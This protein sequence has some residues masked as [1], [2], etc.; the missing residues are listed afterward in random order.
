[1]D[2]DAQSLRLHDYTVLAT[3]GLSTLYGC[4]TARHEDAQSRSLENYD[5]QLAADSAYTSPL[6]QRSQ[7]NGHLDLRNAQVGQSSAR[8]RKAALE[9]GLGSDNMSTTSPSSR[10]QSPVSSARQIRVAT[11]R[12]R[13]GQKRT[14]NGSQDQGTAVG[15]GSRLKSAFARVKTDNTTRTDTSRDVE[16]GGTEGRARKGKAHVATADAAIANT[17]SVADTR[18]KEY[19]EVWFDRYLIMAKLG[20]G[21]FSQ[22]FLA[23]DLFCDRMG[24]KHDG[25][26]LVTIKRMGAREGIIGISDYQTISMLNR[27]DPKERVPIV[28]VYDIFMHRPKTWRTVEYDTALRQLVPT[29]RPPHGLAR[30]QYGRSTSRSLA[31]SERQRAAKAQLR[32]FGGDNS[33]GL[34]IMQSETDVLASSTTGVSG[35]DD[36][37][38][39]LVMEP[40]LGKTLHDAFPQRTSAVYAAHDE[41]IAKQIHMDMIRTVIRQL[42]VALA[43]MHKN[44]LLHADVKT[45]NIICVDD[46]SLRV[47]LIDFGNAVS[48]SDVPEYYTTFE[49][50]TVWFRAPEVAYQRPFG[51][52]IDIWSIGCIMCELWLSRP[53][54]TDMDNHNLISSIFKLRGPPPAHLYSAS[55]VYAEVAKLWSGRPTPGFAPAVVGGRQKGGMHSEPSL[56]WDPQLRRH[57]LKHSL[58]VEDDDFVSLADSLLEY[59]PE[60][61]LTAAEA[62]KHPF[63]QGM[64]A[65]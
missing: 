23:A 47:K 10:L 32:V 39:C 8:K 13:S 41:V 28:R 37:C 64:Y 9:H 52:A 11:P 56:D 61:R 58:H 65:L 45:T 60:D 43:H 26:R 29:Q 51:R 49:I 18:P 50:Q 34:G 35:M 5:A 17:N 21:A 30:D 25:T 53:L 63:F 44:A 33:E 38:V 31:R 55:P 20:E 62:L 27:L 19:G 7:R 6:A 22:A 40:L 42:L 36:C 16:A 57:W 15:V 1:M 12:S 48:D 59:D 2:Y 46:A 24:K 14:R 54:F 3:L 4:V